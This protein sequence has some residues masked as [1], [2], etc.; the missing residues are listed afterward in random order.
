MNKQKN[1]LAVGS[2]AID[3]LETP[4][5]N[6]GDMLGGSASYFSVA[7]S[8][9]A[10]VKLV[11]VVGNDYPEKG[12]KMFKS[13]NINV[14]NVQIAQGI[15]FR[16]GGKYNDDYS[17]RD[18]LFTELGV[19][20]SFSPNIKQKD[21]N[22]PLVFIGNIQPDL[23][24]VVANMVC[25]PE[26]VVSDTMNLW[27]D[28]FPEKLTDVIKKSSV[29]LINHEEA[30]QF[31]GRADIVSA[32]Q[33]LINMGP[34]VVVIKMGAG[35]SYVSHNNRG[36]FV[37]VFPVVRVLDPTG[38]GDSFAGGFMGYLSQT[39]NPDFIEAVIMGS[40]MASFCVEGFGLEALL[41]ATAVSLYDRIKIIKGS[42]PEEAEI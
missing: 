24:L 15:T 32:A 28:L 42:M 11:G 23:Q 12:W 9:L 17:S 5:G 6:C 36:V 41:E 31:T 29:L 8:M 19:F 30:E 13:R 4:M 40:A 34:Q 22:S 35:G 38:A 18:T 2:I 3:T 7:A 39:Q 14:D 25:D 33:I 20:E 1:I 27:I 16:W 10:P 26:H 37:P 21:C